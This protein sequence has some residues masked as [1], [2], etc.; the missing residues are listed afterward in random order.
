VPKRPP[1]LFELL[2]VAVDDGKD[3]AA[4]YSLDL[5]RS[6]EGAAD[7]PLLRLFFQRIHEKLRELHK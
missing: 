5:S 4:E 2:A 7:L 6:D 1:Y 3:R